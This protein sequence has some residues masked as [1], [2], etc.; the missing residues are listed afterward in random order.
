ML[1]VTFDESEANAPGPSDIPG[2]TAGG[3]VG[4]LVLS[5]LIQG[6]NDLGHPL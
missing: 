2:G 1:V 4:A 3:R 6:G 5:P